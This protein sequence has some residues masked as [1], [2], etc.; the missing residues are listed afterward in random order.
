[1]RF[2][3]FSGIILDISVF[4]RLALKCDYLI[5]PFS[6]SYIQLYRPLYQAIL[7]IAAPPP[8]RGAGASTTGAG[9][10]G[11]FFLAPSG[12]RICEE[13]LPCAPA[14]GAPC[15]TTKRPSRWSSCWRRPRRR[16]WRRQLELQHRPFRRPGAGRMGCLTHHS[17]RCSRVS[18]PRRARHPATSG[19]RPA[20]LVHRVLLCGLPAQSRGLPGSLG[21]DL[22]GAP[23]GEQSP[24]CG[25]LLR[26]L[27]NL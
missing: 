15:T 9:A 8:A 13:L 11:L 4:D 3:G 18:L 7:N 25:D 26:A 12:D 16:R 5:P 14:R 10:V 17:R 1:M 23:S 6:S 2:S 19:T 24:R 21:G 20:Y 22:L 27:F